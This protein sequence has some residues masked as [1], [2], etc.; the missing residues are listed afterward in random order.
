VFGSCLCGR[1][2]SE[3]AGR[4]ICPKAARV[5]HR[6]S[7]LGYSGDVRLTRASAAENRVMGHYAERVHF[8]KPNG[9][10]TDSER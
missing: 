5:T 1:E 9:G 3:H 8:V 10:T 2:R 7:G 6:S 4:V